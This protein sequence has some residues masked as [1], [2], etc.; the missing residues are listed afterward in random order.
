MPY[1]IGLFLLI[2]II[3]LSIKIRT[4]IWIFSLIN[5]I[6]ISICFIVPLIIFGNSIADYFTKKIFLKSVINNNFN[7]EQLIKYYRP[8]FY[9]VTFLIASI[10]IYLISYFLSRLYLKI[11]MNRIHRNN[12]LYFQDISHTKKGITSVSIVLTTTCSFSILLLSLSTSSNFFLN[13]GDV[14][15]FHNFISTST[16]WLFNSN[17]GSKVEYIY[18][19]D[20]AHELKDPSKSRVLNALLKPYN[21]NLQSLNSSDI[22]IMSN[23]DHF[24]ELFKKATS[25]ETIDILYKMNLDETRISPREI[26]FQAPN[27]T[28]SSFLHNFFNQNNIH[29]KLLESAAN[30]FVNKMQNYLFLSFDQSDEYLNW[31]NENNELN[32]LITN[33]FNMTFEITSLKNKLLFAHQQKPLLASKISQLN[34]SISNLNSQLQIIETELNQKTNDFLAIEAEWTRL[35]NELTNA[36]SSNDAHRIEIAQNN[37]NNYKSTYD[38]KKLEL[39]TL[40]DKKNFLESNIGTSSNELNSSQIE[41]NNNDALILELEADET[42]L[43]SI[44]H[45]E[46]LITQI[47]ND[48]SI[49]KVEVDNFKKIR[50]SA[51]ITWNDD[52]EDFKNVYKNIIMN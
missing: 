21:F 13:S 10:P 36:Q 14:N 32:T 7:S 26:N 24:I 9:S 52:I 42:N 23:N 51:K 5:F 15:L 49:K 8:T 33:K 29:L 45:K 34:D 28:T 40:S 2:L 31:L 39:V 16:S 25:N 50:D 30:N 27:F 20:I 44:K 35:Q 37:L 3:L 6:I 47:E 11:H 41:A 46:D 17:L 1:L 12:K 48:I 19:R 4:T 43:N 18:S 22:S 38:L